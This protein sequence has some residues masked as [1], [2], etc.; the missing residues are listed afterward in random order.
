MRNKFFGRGF[1][2]DFCS[3]RGSTAIPSGRSN[4]SG[5]GLENFRALRA[6]CN[7]GVFFPTLIAHGTKTRR[8]GVLIFGTLGERQMQCYKLI[9]S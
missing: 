9:E 6:R 5:C 1:L 8:P 7:F 4:V 2:L 3:V